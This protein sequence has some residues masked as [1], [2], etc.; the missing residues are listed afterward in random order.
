MRSSLMRPSLMRP[1]LKFGAHEKTPVGAYIFIIPDNIEAVA[2]EY[3]RDVVDKARPIG[4][5][6]K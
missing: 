2:E 6:H 3:T 1:S 5:V 4:A